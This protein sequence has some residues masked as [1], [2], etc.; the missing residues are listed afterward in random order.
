M[1]DSD[2]RMVVLEMAGKD[3]TNDPLHLEIFIDRGEADNE[4]LERIFDALKDLNK[5]LG[6]MGVTCEKVAETN[7]VRETD[8][9][10]ETDEAPKA[11][12]VDSGQGG[13]S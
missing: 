6:G 11:Q 8:E 5:A 9:I 7:E 3:K 12:E 10:Q 2:D 1:K 4:D 13:S